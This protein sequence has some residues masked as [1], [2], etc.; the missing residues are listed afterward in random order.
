M[1]SLQQPLVSVLISTYNNEKTKLLINNLDI[2]SNEYKNKINI[3][4]FMIFNKINLPDIILSSNYYDLKTLYCDLNI[5]IDS[6][7]YIDNFDY[8][9]FKFWNQLNK[10]ERIS[11]LN[12]NSSNI[13]NEYLKNDGLIRNISKDIITDIAFNNLRNHVV[14]S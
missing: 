9:V 12:K 3:I 7:K 6:K 13:K 1:T 14:N 2:S 4:N 10:D 11:F 5:K 8:K